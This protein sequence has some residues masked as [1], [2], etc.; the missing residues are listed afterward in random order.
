MASR[1][2]TATDTPHRIVC[3]GWRHIDGSIPAGDGLSDYDAWYYLDHVGAF[4]GRAKTY[5]GQDMVYASRAEAEHWAALAS[6]PEAA[7]PNGI[8]PILSVEEDWE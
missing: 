6:A 8:V 4:A 1:Y 3:D 2:D 5:T 7:D